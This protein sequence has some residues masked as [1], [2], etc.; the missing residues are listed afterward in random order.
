MQTPKFVLLL[1][2]G[3][4]DSTVL[5]YHLIQEGCRVHALL[6]DY[7]QRH[8]QELL[9]AKAHCKRLNVLYST[10]E[11]PELRGSELT[12][13]KGSV[14][15]PFRNPIMLSLAVNVAVSI[16][17]ESV[18]IGCNADDAEVFPDCQWATLDALS[19]AIKLSGYSVEIVAPFVN[20]KKWWIAGLG[21]EM[22]VA[23]EDTWSC[24]QGGTKPCGQ[25]IACQKRKEAL[26]YDAHAS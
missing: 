4:L 17:A 13:G 24:Y 6:C 7:K 22:G 5:L 11:L 9:C 2:S 10:L 20:Q 1:L 19:H 25:C 8:A 16:G 15:V 18:A 14:V 12:D 3:G 26:S 23:L 21:R